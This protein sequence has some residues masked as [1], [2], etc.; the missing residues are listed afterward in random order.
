MKL[1]VNIYLDCQTVYRLIT[2]QELYVKKK[3]LT[4]SEHQIR[5][6]T[7]VS[8]AGL[9]GGGSRESR[10]ANTLLLRE[11]LPCSPPPDTPL[12]RPIRPLKAQRVL[13]L[14][15]NSLFTHQCDDPRGLQTSIHIMSHYII[16]DCLT[17]LLLLLLLLRIYIHT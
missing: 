4:L 12:Q 10:G 14:W 11:P 8:A 1:F 13:F 5:G 17:S 6:R 7:A 16:I 15:K 2:V 3:T 9:Q